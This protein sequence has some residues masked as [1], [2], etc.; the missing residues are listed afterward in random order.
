MILKAKE[1][2]KLLSELMRFTKEI[3]AH[4]SYLNGYLSP[5]QIIEIEHQIYI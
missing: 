4:G 3:K 5:Q 1:I 2:K